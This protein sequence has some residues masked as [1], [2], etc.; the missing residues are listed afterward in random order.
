MRR[1]DQRI[2][3][4]LAECSS[5]SQ[6]FGQAKMMAYARC[7]NSSDEFIFVIE[8]EKEESA[9]GGLLNRTYHHFIAQLV[10]LILLASIREKKQC[11][12]ARCCRFYYSISCILFNLVKWP[13]YSY[14]ERNVFNCIF[15]VIVM[16]AFPWAACL[17]VWCKRK[18][19][20]RLKSIYHGATSV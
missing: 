8:R 5:R 15:F 7:R 1:I 14:N 18:N 4:P 19:G 16:V 6:H 9:A 2:K 17:N 10:T 3:M 12:C 13:F 11:V 20:R